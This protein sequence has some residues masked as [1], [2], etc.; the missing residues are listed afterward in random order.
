MIR[1]RKEFLEPELEVIKFGMEDI[2]TTS[3][4]GDVEDTD[5]DDMKDPWA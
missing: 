2:I 3:G 5:S 1:M 4:N